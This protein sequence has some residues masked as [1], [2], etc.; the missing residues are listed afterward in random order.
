MMNIN[1]I[2]IEGYSENGICIKLSEK[3]HKLLFEDNIQ[4]QSITISR[5][6]L[7]QRI[8]WSINS[9]GAIVKETNLYNLHEELNET[10]THV[11]HISDKLKKYEKIVIDDCVLK[12]YSDRLSK[13]LKIPICEHSHIG[14][15]GVCSNI[16]EEFLKK[17]HCGFTISMNI[18]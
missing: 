15:C 17:P 8:G 12:T 16:R 5:N 6:E 10:E 7:I 1:M 9:V 18:L 3:M 14:G 13:F 2:S 4:I 11:C